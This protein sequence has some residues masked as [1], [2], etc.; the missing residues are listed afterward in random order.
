M[1]WIPSGGCGLGPV[2]G[3]WID[4]CP[5]TN[6]EFATFAAE[7]GHCTLACQDADCMHWRY[8][9]GTHDHPVTDVSWADAVAYAAWAGKALP[10]EAEWICAAHDAVDPFPAEYPLDDASPPPIRPV[11]ADLPNGYGLYD[12]VGNVWE[13]TADWYQSAGPVPVKVIM[14]GAANRRLPH[15]VDGYASDL[16]FRCVVRT[17]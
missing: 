5:V 7:T 9:D 4:A 12:M 2:D 6:E 10:T 15:P 11:A 1:V 16:G 17:G 13:W 3:F 14:G 8:P